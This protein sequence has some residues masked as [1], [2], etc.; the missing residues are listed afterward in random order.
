MEIQ[1]HPSRHK[2]CLIKNGRARSLAKLPGSAPVLP[3]GRRTHCH[4]TPQSWTSSR[5][6][7]RP[8]MWVAKDTE[9]VKMCWEMEETCQGWLETKQMAWPLCRW[10]RNHSSK[11]TTWAYVWPRGPGE[12]CRTGATEVPGL[13]KNSQEA[14]GS[15]HKLMKQQTLPEKGL[16]W[17]GGRW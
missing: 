6:S 11:L 4:S 17:A 9:V 7:D 15:I 12:G 10:L 2:S 16:G 5:K 13:A 3:H 8:T 14:G 1:C